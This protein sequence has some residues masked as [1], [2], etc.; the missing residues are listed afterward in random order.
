MKWDMNS[1]PPKAWVVEDGDWIPVDQALVRQCIICSS[2]YVIDPMSNK[3][4]CSVGCNLKLLELRKG[5][6]EEGKKI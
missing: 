2:W 4:V 3:S 1:S 6:N 5:K